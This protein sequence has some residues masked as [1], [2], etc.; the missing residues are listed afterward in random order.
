VSWEAHHGCC[1]STQKPCG[2]QKV[3]SYSIPPQG[4]PL[5]SLLQ[6]KLN[7][8]RVLRV[9]KVADYVRR[10]MEEVGIALRE[11]PLFWDA[12]RAE[13][14]Q[15]EEA[16]AAA[17][18]QGRGGGSLPD[19]IGASPG[20]HPLHPLPHA[21]NG[22]GGAA[23]A[24]GGG[25]ALAA[26]GA[27][28]LTCSGQAVPWDFSLAAVRQWIWRRSDDLVIHYSVRDPRTPLRLPAI[29]PPS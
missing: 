16:A 6:S 9:N 22:G 12:T 28:L 1:C 11:E 7:A 26:A 19:G 10:K 3:K 25:G 13:R 18:Q 8:P 27:V 17:A 5:P 4:S 23:A 14:W 2:P 21:R 24:A 20:V 15:A 29:R